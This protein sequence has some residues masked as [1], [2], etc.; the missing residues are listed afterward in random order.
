MADST[1]Q[2]TWEPTEDG[3]YRVKETGTHYVDVCPMIY[4]WRICLTPKIDPD[5]Y[6]RGYCYNGRDPVSALLAAMEWDPD[7]EPEPKGW[8]K[9]IDGTF[10]RRP[11]GTPESEYVNP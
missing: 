1:T 9:A 4:N 8:V 5:T 6:D 7:T 2:A 3:G 11:D 10:R